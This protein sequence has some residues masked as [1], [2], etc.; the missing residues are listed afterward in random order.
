MTVVKKFIIPCDFG[1]KTSPFAV[2]VGEPKPDAHPVQQQNTWLAK[3]RG[4]Q[5]PERVISS[6]E[7][8]NKLAKENGI[9]LADLCVYALKVAAKNNTDEH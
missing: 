7:K 6:L 4:G 3:E 2:Y 5:L 1:G 9:C 8:L